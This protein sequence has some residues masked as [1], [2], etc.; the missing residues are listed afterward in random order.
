MQIF[1]YGDNLYEMSKAVYWE[2]IRILSIFSS[3]ELAYRME[4][5]QGDYKN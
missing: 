5:V 3:A 1:T 4:K 2:K